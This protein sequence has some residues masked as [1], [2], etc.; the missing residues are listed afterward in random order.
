MEF[1]LKSK[2][3][4]VESKVP[5]HKAI[6]AASSPVFDRM[7]YGDLK[8]EQQ[9]KITDVS[10]EAFC[11]FLQFF[12]IDEI[13]ITPENVF[14]VFR[15]VDKY[16]VQE[17]AKVCEHFLQETVTPNLLCLYYDVALIFDY[18]Q[19]I[20]RKIEASIT[21]NATQALKSKWLARSSEIVIKKILEMD[22]LDCSESDVF[23][24]AISWAIEACT[25]KGQ[26]ASTENLKA[27]LGDCLALI[28]FPCMTAVEFS[29]SME[30]YR[31]LLDY[32][33]LFD[34]MNYIVGDR[35]LTYAKQFNNKPRLKLEFDVSFWNED[36]IIEDRTDR[37]TISVT[38]S[39]DVWLKHCDIIFPFD[40]KVLLC[41]IHLN[42]AEIQE[43][44]E[45]EPLDYADATRMDMDSSS[46]PECY[47]LYR[48]NLK[49]PY[50]C[51]LNTRYNFCF[52]I[53]SYISS[54]L[55]LTDF[56]C[57]QGYIVQCGTDDTNH[58]VKKLHFQRK[59]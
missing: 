58:F 27:E 5:A 14:E 36:V 12:Y 9:V 24:A 17:S 2:F 45:M 32:N 42:E 34:I 59:V 31:D 3:Y 29:I 10:F 30:K 57:G 6:L 43:Y 25:S 16:H 49:Q 18:S 53:R 28:R 39:H 4:D 51:E 44:T 54:Y 40:Q 11:E 56:N 52:E 15:M 8:Q 50:L 21:S 20:I 41:K 37:S 33:Q 13:D 47:R 19:E 23:A 38:V 1:V 7:F 46:C 26:L 55:H 48:L 22:E 35:P